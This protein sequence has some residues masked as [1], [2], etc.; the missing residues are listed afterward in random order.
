M[1]FTLELGKV[2]I[3]GALYRYWK[4]I[5]KLKYYLSFAVLVLIIITSLGIYGYLSHAYQVTNN[6]LTIQEKISQTVIQK[7]DR[8]EEQKSELIKEKDVLNQS[9]SDLTKALSNPTTIQYIDRET[10]QLVTTTRSSDRKVFTE[11]LEMDK[12]RLGVLSNKLDVLNDS[13]TNFEIKLIEI[14]SN[15]QATTDLGPIIY[16]HKITGWSMDKLVSIFILLIVIVFDPLAIA[17]VLFFSIIINPPAIEIKK[18]SIE[19]IE[20]E[21]VNNDIENIINFPET[22][23]IEEESQQDIPINIGEIFDDVET[24]EEN[25]EEDIKKKST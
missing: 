5:N 2:I 9:I 3:A 15:S 10:G 23:I 14:S 16:L 17:M 24:V 4:V 25:P 18:E 12:Q 21:I 8:Y 11:Q 1:A 20:E 13:I 22:E 7:R 6:Q 19:T